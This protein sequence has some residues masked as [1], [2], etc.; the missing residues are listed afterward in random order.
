MYMQCLFKNKTVILYFSQCNCAIVSSL[1]YNYIHVHVCVDNWISGVVHHY[2]KRSW[3]ELSKVWI[4]GPTI[5]RGIALPLLINSTVVVL[6]T[7]SIG[8]VTYG[9]FCF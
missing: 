8:D 1:K 3:W 7:C 9:L 6:V 2:S 5:E 4:T